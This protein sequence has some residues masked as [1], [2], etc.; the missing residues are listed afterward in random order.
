[1]KAARIVCVSAQKLDVSAF[2][3]KLKRNVANHVAE[4]EDFNAEYV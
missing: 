4:L 3:K 1:M 2:V